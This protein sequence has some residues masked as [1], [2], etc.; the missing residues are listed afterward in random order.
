MGVSAAR[1]TGRR[2]CCF[3]AVG[4]LA[5]PTLP[6]RALR[7][8]ASGCFVWPAAKENLD[9]CGF[10]PP[11]G[12][13]THAQCGQGQSLLE[14]PRARPQSLLERR[15]NRRSITGPGSA[16]CARMTRGAVLRSLL[17]SHDR[18]CLQHTARGTKLREKPV[19]SSLSFETGLERRVA[20]LQRYG[21]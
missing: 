1:V 18:S 10:A 9:L 20:A 11:L 16:F 21:A 4:L 19:C 2:G 5:Q 12:L 13:K 17:H 3:S 7:G 8:A 14:R 15:A 6:R